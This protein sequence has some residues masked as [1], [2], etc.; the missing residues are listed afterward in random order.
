MSDTYPP[1]TPRTRSRVTGSKENTALSRTDRTYG[2]TSDTT[3]TLRWD[4]YRQR[5]FEKFT[6]VVTP[7]YRKESASGLIVMN[8][9]EKLTIYDRNPWVRINAHVSDGG[10]YTGSIRGFVRS[11]NPHDDDGSE[12]A[13][14]VGLSSPFGSSVYP[15]PIN[16]SERAAIEAELAVTRAYAKIGE[17]DFSIFS[18]LGELGQT[19]NMVNRGLSSAMP[20][21]RRLRKL[22]L[23][24]LAGSV[25]AVQASNIWLGIRYGLRPLMYDLAGLAKAV[26]KHGSSLRLSTRTSRSWISD[27]HEQTFI[28][29]T[30]WARSPFRTDEPYFVTDHRFKEVTRIKTRAGVLI[31]RD[32]S[33]ANWETVLGITEF[34]TAVWDLIPYSFVWDWFFNFADIIAAFS[35]RGSIDV[36]GS[37][38][39]QT[40]ET[41]QS[42]QLE[43]PRL[44]SETFT[45][46]T[47]YGFSVLSTHTRSRIVKKMTRD[48]GVRPSLVP[49][50]TVNMN[51]LK[52]LDLIAL[53]TS[54]LGR[55][56]SDFDQ[57]P[58]YR[59]T[60]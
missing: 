20:L 46:L 41:L 51:P 32:V 37:W 39:V 29:Q 19:V 22:Q 44:N 57:G 30:M 4:Y 33:V 45:G 10:L 17:I 38:C 18:S 31:S 34:P 36:L 24:Q 14:L 55:G 27:P 26:Q 12:P 54:L 42:I 9:C 35:P 48:V 1:P 11:Y 15:N 16:H 23:R 13:G 8:P 53:L 6:D 7:A 3:T 59:P 58:G 43:N 56:R 5:T 60:D 28:G 2:E 40:V 21:L 25:T 49:H 50:V 47:G 52:F